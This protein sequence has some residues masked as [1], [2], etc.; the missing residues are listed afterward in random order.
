MEDAIRAGDINE[1]SVLNKERE[2]ARKKLTQTKNRF[3]KRMSEKEVTVTED[4]VA[5]VV[6]RITHTTIVTMIGN[7]ILSSLDRS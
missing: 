6:G 5:G 4:D 3:Q 2:E 1:A 7:R